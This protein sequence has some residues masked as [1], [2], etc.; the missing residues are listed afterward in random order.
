MLILN[1]LKHSKLKL[2]LSYAM[3]EFV[4]HR[5]VY[6]AILVSPLSH[7]LDLILDLKM[8]VSLVLINRRDLLDG[9]D[10]RWNFH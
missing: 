4:F 9:G 3:V 8:A 6:I 7:T 10:Q 5:P 2:F 1:F